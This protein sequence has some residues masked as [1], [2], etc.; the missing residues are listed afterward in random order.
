MAV[1]GGQ[2]G[3]RDD[4]VHYYSAT[5]ARAG[6]GSRDTHRELEVAEAA[7]WFEPGREGD[8]PMQ[9]PATRGRAAGSPTAGAVPDLRGPPGGGGDFLLGV[10][11]LDAMYAYP[12]TP[13]QRRLATDKAP[14]EAY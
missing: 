4:H 10:L 11:V 3:S 6:E 5:G 14:Y 7:A 12:A 1:A 2:S 8:L 13:R 9:H